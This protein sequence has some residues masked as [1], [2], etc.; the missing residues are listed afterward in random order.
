MKMC[1]VN[2]LVMG[3][4]IKLTARDGIS[5]LSIFCRNP[6]NTLEQS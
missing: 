2:Q 4:K 1:G 6:Y 3:Y 5:G